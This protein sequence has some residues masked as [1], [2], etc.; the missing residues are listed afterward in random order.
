MLARTRMSVQTWEMMHWRAHD[1]AITGI[2]WEPNQKLVWTTS[3]DRKVKVRTRLRPCV[4]ARGLTLVRAMQVW[5]QASGLASP[6]LVVCEIDVGRS[7]GLSLS[8]PLVSSHPFVCVGHRDGTVSV[9]DAKVPAR[10]AQHAHTYC[11]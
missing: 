8:A 3:H 4:R 9:W 11:F 10:H 6:G 5:Q 2:V 1:Q 7:Y